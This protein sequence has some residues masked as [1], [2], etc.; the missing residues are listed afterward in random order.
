MTVRLPY[1]VD[2][3]L[4]SWRNIWRNKK[5]IV[6]DRWRW[7]M[8]WEL[9]FYNKNMNT[10]RI[11]NVNSM[12]FPTIIRRIGCLSL[13]EHALL[14]KSFWENSE[15]V[16][17]A[18]CEYKRQKTSFKVP[19]TASCLRRIVFS[20]LCRFRRQGDLKFSKGE[21][22][23]KSYSKWLKFWKLLL[24]NSPIKIHLVRVMLAP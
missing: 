21:Y 9:N 15:N 16:C 23:N 12:N 8:F 7:K 3:H 22:E 19:L 4:R 13:K 14:L 6:A 11:R 1:L 2:L 24:L 17:S 5:I 10:P 20:F 18:I